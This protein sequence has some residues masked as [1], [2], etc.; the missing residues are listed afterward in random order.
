M[1]FVT[2]R[3]R[4]QWVPLVGAVLLVSL[5][6]CGNQPLLVVDEKDHSFII[7]ESSDGIQLVFPGLE[8]ASDL[9][10]TTTIVEFHNLDDGSLLAKAVGP[11]RKSSA[12]S[13][14]VTTSARLELGRASNIGI[15]LLNLD[16]PTDPECSTCSGCSWSTSQAV[17]KTT[18]CGCNILDFFPNALIGE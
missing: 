10:G 11:Y 18:M 14:N 6:G 15:S 17:Y 1:T 2:T 3:T 7:F 5:L 13:F 9:D 16:C 8:V 4:A 12:H